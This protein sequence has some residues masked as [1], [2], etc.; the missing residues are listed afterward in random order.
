MREIFTEFEVDAPVDQVWS[1]LVDIEKWHEW[2]P[3]IPEISGE[4]SVGSRLKVRIEP[5]GGKPMTFKPTV[6]CFQE[7]RDFIWVGTIPIPGAF[8]GEH[9]FELRPIDDSRTKVIHREEFSGWM[10]PFLWKNLDKDA[11]GGFQLMNEALKN[12]AEKNR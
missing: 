10:L 11:R 8:R 9:I 4:V 12:E 5:P 1:V 7:N 3:F 2:N 6:S